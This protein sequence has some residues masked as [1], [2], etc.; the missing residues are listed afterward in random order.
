MDGQAEITIQV[1]PDVADAY[2]RFP[3]DERRT[4][5]S[6]IRMVLIASMAAIRSHDDGQH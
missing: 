2:R 4:I 3:E 5:D 1:S 6:R